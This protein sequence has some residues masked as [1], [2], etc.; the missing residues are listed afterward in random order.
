MNQGFRHLK[1]KLGA[2]ENGERDEL[3]AA[4]KRTRDIFKSTP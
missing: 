4:L 2:G 1:T 3:A